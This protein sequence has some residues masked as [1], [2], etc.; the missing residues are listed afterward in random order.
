M[1]KTINPQLLALGIAILT[2]FILTSCE[3]E[4]SEIGVNIQPG[5]DKIILATD[6]LSVY[7]KTIIDDSITT[8]ER[9]LS[10]LGSYN[11]S[12]FGQTN[13]SFITQVTL[14]SG[15]ISEDTEVFPDSLELVMEYDNYFGDTIAEITF[16][17]Y[18]IQSGEFS[19]EESY[20]SNYNI[21]EESLSLIGEYSFSPRPSDTVARFMIHQAEFVQFFSEGNLYSNSEAFLD[22]FRGLL[23]EVI[24]EENENGCIA[25]FDLLSEKSGL[26]MYYNG[27][28]TYNFPIDNS[29]VRINLFEH[30]YTS[31]DIE[32]QNSLASDELSEEISF[33]QSAAGLKIQLQ[34]ADTAKLNQLITKGINRAQLQLTIAAD[35]VN[36]EALPEKLTLVY[37]N[38]DSLYEFLTDYKISSDH[39]GGSLNE[40]DQSYT[41]NVPLYLQDLI[42]GSISMDNYL[43]LFALDNRININQCAIY[44]GSHPDYPLQIKIISSEF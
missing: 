37:Q 10:L 44:G 40:E 18:H 11:D 35:Y 24:P 31:S 39:F 2:L 12:F 26:I 27:S 28:E 23:L 14:S 38:D 41:F 19:V 22:D 29:C 30:D 20:F 3:K 7:T 15:N 21:H 8:D 4:S 6:T 17:L 13:T 9:S 32:L 43:H 1:K 42:D 34:I 25:Y 16:N 5:A 33:L 36:P